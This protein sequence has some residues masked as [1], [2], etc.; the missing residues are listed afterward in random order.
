VVPAE[1]TVGPEGLVARLRTP[2]R[3]VAA[4]QAIV[5][6]RPDPAGDIVL[7]SATIA[8]AVPGR[9]AAADPAGSG[10]RA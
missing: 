3:G 7:G 8:D 9:A 10:R 6:Y 1:V 4:G 5:A 2:A